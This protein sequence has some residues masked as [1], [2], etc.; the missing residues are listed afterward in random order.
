MAN[1]SWVQPFITKHSEAMLQSS[2]DFAITG[3][4]LVM[5]SMLGLTLAAPFNCLS[6]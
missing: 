5:R 2:A 4:R 1:F 3:C 6:L